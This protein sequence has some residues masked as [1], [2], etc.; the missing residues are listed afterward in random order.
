MELRTLLI[1]H[2]LNFTKFDISIVG[3]KMK[4]VAF[5]QSPHPRF[6]N[7]VIYHPINT[8]FIKMIVKVEKTLKLESPVSL[9]RH[10]RFSLTRKPADYQSI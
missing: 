10:F 2:I 9:T 8:W 7:K 1:L 6:V 4:W 3:F 5:S